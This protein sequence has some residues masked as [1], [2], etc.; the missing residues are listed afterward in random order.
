MKCFCFIICFGILLTYFSAEKSN[1]CWLTP[2]PTSIYVAGGIDP[3]L[4]CLGCSKCFLA[5]FLS[6][7]QYIENVHKKG[8]LWK[9]WILS[10]YSILLFYFYCFRFWFA[11]NHFLHSKGKHTKICSVIEKI[12]LLEWLI[13]LVYIFFNW[14]SK[15]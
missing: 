8:S 2:S 5:D 12:H 11:L 1:L 4:E 3:M 13:D 6:I 10:F 14:K 15:Q 7:L 9:Q